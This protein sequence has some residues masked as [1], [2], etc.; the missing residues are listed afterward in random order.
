MMEHEGDGEGR[1]SVECL[2]W[3]KGEGLRVSPL[4]VPPLAIE[5]KDPSF[6]SGSLPTT[7]WDPVG[8]SIALSTL[9]FSPKGREPLSI[10]RRTYTRS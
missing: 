5:T 1:R 7:G 9:T 8:R 10:N 2:Y 6:P 3:S 4:P